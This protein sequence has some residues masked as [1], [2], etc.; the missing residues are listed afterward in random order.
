MVLNHQPECVYQRVAITNP[1]CLIPQWYHRRTSREA[2][3]CRSILHHLPEVSDWYPLQNTMVSGFLIVSGVWGIVGRDYSCRSMAIINDPCSEHTEEWNIVKF[4]KGLSW[5]NR[6]NI[7]NIEHTQYQWKIMFPTKTLWGGCRSDRPRADQGAPSSQYSVN[8]SSIAAKTFF[9]TFAS[10]WSVQTCLQHANGPPNYSSNAIRF[11]HVYTI[12]TF[13]VW[14]CVDTEQYFCMFNGFQAQHGVL[15]KLLTAMVGCVLNGACHPNGHF[16]FM[17]DQRKWV[18]LPKSQTNPPEG[19]FLKWGYPIIIHPFYIMGISWIYHYKA[20]TYWG[21]PGNLHGKKHCR[22]ST[23]RPWNFLPS[24]GK[25]L[26]GFCRDADDVLN[27]HCDQDVDA[28]EIQE[29]HWQP[30]WD[31][32]DVPRVTWLRNPGGLF[33]C[34]KKEVIFAGIICTEVGFPAMFDYWRIMQ[35]QTSMKIMKQWTGANRIR[36]KDLGM[37]VILMHPNFQARGP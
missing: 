16:D 37:N 26:S 9:S 25:A 24:L 19:G 17:I 10:T 11:T 5:L 6:L 13:F 14:V 15:V 35:V 1:P 34:Y 36:P 27:H 3:P 28:T 22:V 2:G 23:K 12:V 29:N 30:E 8:S 20:S 21:N 32:N 18:C 4:L 31:T 33:T 7:L